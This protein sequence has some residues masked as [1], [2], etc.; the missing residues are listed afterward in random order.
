MIK[1]RTE[2]TLEKN[3]FEITHKDKILLIGS[4]FAEEVGRKLL[5]HGFNALINPFGVIFNPFSIAEI[6]HRGV[7]GDLENLNIIHHKARFHALDF[8]G[9][10]QSEDEKSLLDKIMVHVQ[11]LYEWIRKTDFLFITWGT[12][13][14]YFLRENN[15][16]VANCHKLPQNLYGNRRLKIGEITSCYEKLIRKVLEVNPKINFIFSVSPVRY[17]N[18]GMHENQLSKATLLLAC[19]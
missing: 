2:L 9:N 3:I 1:F 14:V 11:Q 12:A 5:Q 15:K 4:C 10:F 7:S 17:F 19:D 13:H 16:I 8:H 18:F 6:L